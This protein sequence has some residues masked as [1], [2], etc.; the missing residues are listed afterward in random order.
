MNDMSRQHLREVIATH[1]R[2]VCHDPQ[3]CA[4]LLRAACPDELPDVELLLKTLDERVPLRLLALPEGM[5][6]EAMTAPLVRRLVNDLAITEAEA[7]WAVDSWGV[8]LGKVSPRALAIM[9]AAKPGGELA[10][11][12]GSSPKRSL[13][14]W[15]TGSSA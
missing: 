2:A 11:A 10:G 5:P 7:R 14:H 15:L 4:A 12:P 8:A 3:E 1:G 9:A 6:W 13:W